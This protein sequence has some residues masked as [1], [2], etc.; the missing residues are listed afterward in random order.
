MTSCILL[1]LFMFLNVSYLGSSFFIFGLC[2]YT[3]RMSFYVF[4]FIINLYFINGI[5]NYT[6]EWAYIF[7]LLYLFNKNI[8]LGDW[9]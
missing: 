8:G 2:L 3:G 6:I 1:P 4:L 5:K 7:I 9:W